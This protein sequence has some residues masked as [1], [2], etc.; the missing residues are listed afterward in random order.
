[1]PAHIDI[2]K[3][4]PTTYLGDIHRNGIADDVM[5]SDDVTNFRYHIGDLT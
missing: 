3:K 5:V 4:I 2:V 1:M